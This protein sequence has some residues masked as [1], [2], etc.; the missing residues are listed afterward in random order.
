LLNSSCQVTA[1]VL[2]WKKL[3]DPIGARDV[4]DR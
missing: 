3:R 1:T 4:R 2:A